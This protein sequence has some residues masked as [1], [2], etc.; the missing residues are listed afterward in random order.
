MFA[1]EPTSL[2]RAF[3]NAYVQDLVL[4]PPVLDVGSGAFGSTTYHHLIPNFRDAEVHSIDAS[5]ARNPTK[6]ADVEQGIPYEDGKFGT[7]LLFNV[8]MYLYTAPQ[9]LREVRRVLRPFGRICLAAP[10][11]ARVTVE[12]SEYY[13]FIAP[14]YRR[15][16]AEAGFAEIEVVPLGTGPSG[17]ALGQI[18]F[19]LPRVLRS[20]S[21]RAA[22]ILDNLL[23]LR[24][25]GRLR[26]EEHYPLGYVVQARKPATVA[27]LP[28]RP[29]GDDAK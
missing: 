10:L 9:V 18:E 24:A 8:M 25:S 20:V 11:L 14:A 15:M 27:E 3:M 12:P 17:A 22:F 4:E 2:W 28:V 7:C 23:T 21:C 16:L 1:A 19:L 13:R 6:V 26:T 5:P 29:S